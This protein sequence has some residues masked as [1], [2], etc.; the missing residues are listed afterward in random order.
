MRFAKATP[1]NSSNAD[2]AGLIVVFPHHRS[3]SQPISAIRSV[4]F[5]ETSQMVVFPRSSSREDKIKWYC[6]QDY[7]HFKRQR[8]H[9][10]MHCSNLMMYKKSRGESFTADDV[11]RF[12]GLEFLMSSNITKRMSKISNERQAH[13][14]LVLTGQEYM[15]RANVI[16][17]KALARLSEKSS[18][19]ARAKSQKMAAHLL[20]L[21]SEVLMVME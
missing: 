19:K 14:A 3:T 5:S 2:T 8:N 17:A 9:D 18:R 1:S 20:L 10:T 15:R 4:R 16:D 13:T 6:E 7:Q 11:D 12:T 21:H